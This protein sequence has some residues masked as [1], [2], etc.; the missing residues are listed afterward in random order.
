M[1]YKY[2]SELATHILNEDGVMVLDVPKIN[3][4]SWY[5]WET[6]KEMILEMLNKGE[7]VF[8]LRLKL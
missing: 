3:N 6:R 8:P 7:I 2:P 4:E 1:K 5:N